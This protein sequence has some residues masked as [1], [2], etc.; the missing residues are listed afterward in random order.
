MASGRGKGAGH[1]WTKPGSEAE[2][3]GWKIEDGKR[4][5]GRFGPHP[6]SSNL[7]PRISSARV[8]ASVAAGSAPSV[9]AGGSGLR[10]AG[11]P[12]T[13][14]ERKRSY[15]TLCR[16]K[17]ACRALLPGTRGRPLFP[18]AQAPDDLLVTGAVLA[19]QVLEQLVPPADQLQQ[20]AA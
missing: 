15:R 12:G 7:D 8:C 13:E 19:G 1:R 10:G 20:A 17:H 6:R 9:S 3:R 14:I 2:G 16:N 5:V 4:A 18:Q 11:E